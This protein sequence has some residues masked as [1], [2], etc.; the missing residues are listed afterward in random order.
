M[1]ERET[2]EVA[3]PDEPTTEVASPITAGPGVTALQALLKK[4]VPDIAQVLDIV[5]RRPSDIQEVLQLVQSLGNG[6]YQNLRKAMDDSAIQPAEASEPADG[7]VGWS[8]ANGRFT[9]TVNEEGLGATYQFGKSSAVHASVNGHETALALQRSG[10]SVAEIY[11]TR[12]EGEPRAVGV[13]ST[14]D[15]GDGATLTPSLQHSEAQN[16][17]A[18]KYMGTSTHADGYAGKRTSDGGFVAGVKADYSNDRTTLDGSAAYSPDA[19]SLSGNATHKLDERTELA[20]NLTANQDKTTALLSGTRQF[21]PTAKGAAS[22]GYDE[23]WNASAN[24]EAKI[25]DA[26]TVKGSA[27]YD[28]AGWNAGLSATHQLDKRTALAAN[29][30][31]NQ[32]KTTALLSGTRQFN[33]TAKGAASIGYDEGWNASANAEAKTG[34]ATTVKGSAHYDPAGWNAG[35]SAA[36]TAK[37][38]T[39][40]AGITADQDKTVAKLAGTQRFSPT[41]TGDAKLSR[42]VAGLNSS[43]EASAALQYK[44]PTLTADGRLSYLQAGQGEGQTTL[45]IHERYQSAKVIE[46]L[47]IDAGAGARDFANATGSIDAQLGQHLYGGAWGSVSTESGKPT[48]SSIG[49]SITWT[50]SDKIALT[51]AGV[52]NNAGQIE[53]RLQ[54]DVFKQRVGLADIADHKKDALISF[55]VGIATN[56]GGG[57][58]DQRYG[59]GKYKSDGTAGSTQYTVGV[60][61]PF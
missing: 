38:T 54:L 13:R 26:T 18:L 36:Y 49:A 56:G 45:S 4:G 24:A 30:T 40:D 5:N 25:G 46:K 41:T 50:P 42:T 14:F 33:P 55:Y 12:D 29:L 28:P 61:L 17:I 57:M 15:V 10:K 53:G 60:K 23:G 37:D 59:A 52:T 9:G 1:S 35:L 3:I 51:A 34:D 47:N 11:A 22:I 31:A 16:Q 58:L 7:A 19:W 43:T 20:A 21:S 6:Y 2:A 48:Q 27:H 44:D 8:K 32:D 39:V